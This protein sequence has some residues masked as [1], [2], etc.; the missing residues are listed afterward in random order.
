MTFTKHQ[1]F[2][3]TA[4][5]YNLRFEVEQ[6]ADPLESD[7]RYYSSDANVAAVNENGVVTAVAKG[8][9]RIWAIATNG[10]RTSATVTVK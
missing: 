10:V 2:P 9:C 3:D 5:N 7:K 4:G 6:L 1:L 8:S